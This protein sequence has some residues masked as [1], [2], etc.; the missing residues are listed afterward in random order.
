MNQIELSQIEEKII[1]IR[2]MQ[3]EDIPCIHDLERQAFSDAWSEKNLE[4]VC[5]QKHYYNVVAVLEDVVV[6]YIIATHVL[7]E[8]ELL[9]IAV[10]KD[11]RMHGIG[12]QLLQHLLDK[13]TKEQIHTCFLEVRQSNVAAIALYEKQGFVL[14]GRR[15][16]YYKN[17]T[18]NANIMSWIYQK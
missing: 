10:A 17:P 18:E 8:G 15:K 16:N 12:E 2:S 4:E 6:G 13:F 1:Q 14:Q 3:R 5:E 7:D 9:R 11:C